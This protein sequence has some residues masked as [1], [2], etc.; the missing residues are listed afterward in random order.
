MHNSVVSIIVPCYNQAQYLSESL[1]SVLDQSYTYWEC[2]IINDGSSDDTEEVALNWTK[3]DFRFKYLKKENAG[4]SAA[5]NSGIKLS[6][7]KYILSLD[8]DDLIESTYLEKA[9]CVLENNFDIGIVYCNASYFGNKSGRWILPTHSLKQ[10]LISNTI[11]CTALFRKSDFNI[12]NGYN[13][14]MVDGYEDWDFWLCLIERGIKVSKISE[15]LFFYRIRTNS[16]NNSIDFKKLICLHNQ[17]IQNHIALY[18]KHFR[19]PYIIIDYLEFRKG[20]S[21]G[22]IKMITHILKNMSLKVF[23]FIIHYKLNLIFRL[24][25]AILQ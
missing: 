21:G 7:G 9:V 6:I 11:F 12:T 25:A 24:K 16:R 13:T 4:V 18:Q 2:I 22:I 17:I 19:N 23:I 1:R 14:N 10:S 15:N 3:K 8:A 20:L 5:R